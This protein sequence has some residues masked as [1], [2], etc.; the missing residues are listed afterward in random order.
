MATLDST[1][2]ASQSTERRT[3]FS[4]S[5]RRVG[6]GEHSHPRD[7]SRAHGAVPPDGGRARTGDHAGGDDPG[8]H[9]R[10]GPSP[11][12]CRLPGVRRRRQTPRTAKRAATARHTPGAESRG[13]K[14]NPPAR[15]PQNCPHGV[16]ATCEPNLL[17]DVFVALAQQADEQGELHSA[18]EGCGQDDDRRD[19]GPAPH[20]AQEMR[21]L[22]SRSVAASIARR[23]PKA[24]G[25]AMQQASRTQVK[26]RA[27]SESG[28]AAEE[29]G[30]GRP[31]QPDARQCHRQ[32]QP[33]REGGP[34]E[35]RAEHAVPNEF[36]EEEREA[37]DCRPRHR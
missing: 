3:S 34:A 16:P 1:P 20:F 14:P 22:A 12:S 6:V 33:E 31:A 10:D 25:I 15:D 28:A 4:Q 7:A 9:G 30:I 35:N 29:H 23:S 13:N 21:V 36:H 19:H 32:Y 37:C 24:K 8:S 2:S 26:A 27:W 5:C 11:A 17:A 18:D